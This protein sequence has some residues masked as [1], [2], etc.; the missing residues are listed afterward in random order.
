L[1][2]PLVAGRYY[3]ELNYQER[4]VILLEIATWYFFAGVAVT[5]CHLFAF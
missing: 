1:A 3:L 5:W 2:N 4:F